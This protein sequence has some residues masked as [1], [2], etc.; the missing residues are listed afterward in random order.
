MAK[1]KLSSV[2]PLNQLLDG[3]SDLTASI[4]PNKKGYFHAIGV[5]LR[6]VVT[7]GN[8]KLPHKKKPAGTKRQRAVTSTIEIKMS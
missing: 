5:A 8:F 4:Q 2:L 7:K 3:D 6:A 1:T